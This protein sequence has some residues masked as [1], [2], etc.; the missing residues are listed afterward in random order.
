MGLRLRRLRVPLALLCALGAVLAGLASG[1]ESR[2]ETATAV[3]VTQDVSAGDELTAAVLE[4][5]SV[6]AEAVPGE[7]P[8]RVEDLLGRQAAVP[9][10]RGAMVLPSQ[11]VGPGLL[12]GQPEDHVA[13]PVRPADTA[14]V[15]MLSPGQRVDVILSSESLEDGTSSRTVARAALVLW[16]PSGESDDWFPQAGDAGQVLVV[17]V[18]PSTAQDIAQA[19]HEGRLHLSLVG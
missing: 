10:S 11:L 6:D 2:G 14:L 18:D 15:G 1:V 4:E 7:E 9:L 19:A 12:A 3:R 8:V 5:V 13:V 17:G 16:V